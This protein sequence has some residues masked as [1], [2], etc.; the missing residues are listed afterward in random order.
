MARYYDLRGNPN[1][2]LLLTEEFPNCVTVDY[3]PP[4]KKLQQSSLNAK[5][6]NDR[7]QFKK[8]LLMI[9]GQDN[10]LS[11]YP[12]NTLGGHDR[13]LE[14]KYERIKSIT[15]E[16]FRFQTPE[17]IDGVMLALEEMPS[18]FVK[19]YEYGLG[20]AKEYRFIIDVVEEIEGVEH[21]VI[22]KKMETGLKEFGFVFSFEE[23]EG[24]RKGLNRITGNY[25]AEA[26]LDK[27]LFAHNSVLFKHDPEK[28]P[29]RKKPLKN[30]VIFKLVS[31]TSCD[32]S[33]N[34]KD[35][36]AMVD[37]VSRNRNS[38]HK[39]SRK[40]VL[41]LK[42]DIE[43]LDLEWLMDE[44]AKLLAKKSSEDDW[45][46]LLADNPYL[47]SLV[48][49]YPI[50]KIEGQASVG[51]RKFSGSGEKITDFLVKNQLTN[52]AALVEIKKPST[53]LL[54][55]SEYRSGIY[56]PSAELAGSLSQILDQ[57]YKFQKEI[58]VIKDN[59][60]V[61]DIESYAVD[62]VLIIGMTPEGSDR[63]K[64]FELA[65]YNSK[66]V[67]IVTFDE[68]VAK[69]KDVHSILMPTEDGKDAELGKNPDIS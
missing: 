14:S 20:L 18:A 50:L 55:K 66:D 31:T 32:D 51:G 42:Q 34:P 4:L 54:K 7:V 59:S 44:S 24:L 23:F 19:D 65:R 48:F 62:C 43:L 25:R 57:K 26:R 63:K 53:K 36:E 61:Y 16:G 22:S 2:D 35:A 9:N 37:L 52:N 8:E 1:E 27:S 56:A 40:K 69:L 64:S 29:E 41:D 17:T 13:F 21:I 6:E 15:L 12:L 38:I 33:A 67:K 10:F 5:D 30:D 3:I 11:I 47:L 39:S 46:I 68:L 45:Q 28:Y 58:A 60:G 49:G